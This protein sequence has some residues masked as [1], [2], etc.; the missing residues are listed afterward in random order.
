MDKLRKRADEQRDVYQPEFFRLHNSEDKEQLEQLVDAQKPY[1]HDEMYD[2]LKELVKSR[3]PTRPLSN[4]DYESLIATHLGGV[5]LIEFGVWVYYPWNN[6]LVHILDREEFIE[7]RTSRNQYKITKAEQ[8]TLAQKKVG[9]IGL[10]VGQSVSVTMAMERGCGELRLAD[11]DVLELT[12]YNR[13][14][15]SL[16]NLGVKKVVA[17]AREIMEI[18]PYLVVKCYADGITEENIGS[19]IDDGTGKLDLLIDECDSVD[20]KI[21]CRLKAKE[22]QIPVLMEASDRGT[23]DVERYDLEPE[24][25]I[26]HGKVAHLDL[27]KLKE[28][29]SYE[30]KVP[31][32]LPIAGTDTLS[33]RM[34]ASMLEIGRTITTWPQLASA[35]AL[36]GG[37]TAD[38]ARRIFLDEY[39]ESGR[40]FIDIE[41]LISDKEAP[42]AIME[43][44]AEVSQEEMDALIAKVNVS[45]SAGTTTLSDEAISELVTAG[46]QAY[47]KGNQQPWRWKYADGR[48][49][50]FYN[51]TRN[52]HNADLIA[53]GAATENIVLKAHE[54][55]LE[56]TVSHFPMRTDSHL[57]A[58]Y[59]FH[60]KNE[61]AAEPHIADELVTTIPYRATDVSITD[62]KPID[63]AKLDKL[64]QIAQ[65][66]PGASLKLI[67]DEKS[68]AEVSELIAKAERLR[69][70]DENGGHADFVNEIDWEEQNKGIGTGLSE[71]RLR[72]SEQVAY[73]MVKNLGV[74]KYLNKWNAGYALEWFARKYTMSAS[75][76]G[77]LTMPEQDDQSLFNGGRA[78]ER[79][80]L[81]AN[82]EGLG[83]Q[84]LNTITYLFD[85][86]STAGNGRFPEKAMNDLREMRKS[87]EKI[88]SLEN[89]QAAEV[90][91]FRLFVS[92]E[93][94]TPS[95][96]LPIEKLLS[97]SSRHDS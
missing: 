54:K 11:F 79:I 22:A 34:K 3:N 28:L 33:T 88:F 80:W 17:V 97:F 75:V 10:S 49:Y 37:I 71:L 35:V 9:V 41:Q 25:P 29:K 8:D 61:G 70:L 45:P 13:I 44:P 19:F 56:I 63:A 23:I 30:E 58:V 93:P 52:K 74:I 21:L 46:A 50:L 94:A 64:Q 84:P 76:I 89:S 24:R 51:K 7:A 38:V 72:P 42:D 96:H 1:I 26:L 55:G 18:D 39:H 14:R 57:A 20:I 86:L 91:L 73:H 43:R 87:Y 32:I 95:P 6:R 82:K 83:F 66:I 59:S 68:M 77:L 27:G 60:N 31:Y 85:E 53:L 5:S 16:H 90:M 62:K 47:S 40:Y 36:G 67:S 78:L 92:T 81:A 48:L 69:L 15:T 65:T 12:N 4:E 2:Q